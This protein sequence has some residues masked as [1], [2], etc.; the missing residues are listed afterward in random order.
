M[1]IESEGSQSSHDQ[2]RSKQ[3]L[4]EVL[5]LAISFERNAYS[6]YSELAPK[7]GKRLRSLVEGLAAEELQH[8]TLFG[9][10]MSNPL[11]QQQLP[12]LVVTPPSHRRFV[13]AIHAVGLEDE[14]DEQA[15]LRYALAREQTA[16]EQ[17]SSLAAELAP[18]AIRDLLIFL[19]QQERDH[20]NALEKI[21]SQV[22]PSGGR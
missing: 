15:I 9:A 5:E 12:Q 10:L 13:D 3:S 18:G 14:P 1:S 19:S 6:F 2:M 8:I 4:R 20:K 16:M 7:V 21:H 22:A 11:I 17:Y